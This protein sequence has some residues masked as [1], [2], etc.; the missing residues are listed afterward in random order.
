VP[1][2]AMEADA[3]GWPVAVRWKGMRKPLFAQGTGDLVV[4]EVHGFSPRWLLVDLW[5]NHAPD[6]AAEFCREHVR[7]TVATSCGKVE[8]RDNPHTRVFIQSLQHPR[9]LWA[10][11][12]LEVWKS[13]PRARLTLR[14]D[15]HSSLDPEIILAA[16]CL[17]CDDVLPQTSCGGQPFTPFID[18]LPGTCR[19]YFAIDHYVRYSGNEGHWYWV[20]RDCPTVAF[21][22]P[23][24]L[25]LHADRPA[26]MNRLHAIVFNNCWNTNW[27]ADSHGVMEFQFD[28]LWSDNRGLPVDGHEL[29]ECVTLDPPILLQPNAKAD[30]LLLRHVFQP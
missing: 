1:G 15:R 9:F 22:S 6:A 27:V 20:S 29:A 24:V 4:V 13:E 10:K 25:A 26:D 23:P 21:G 8:V 28:L 12:R 17:P 30:A 18:Q 19:D 11:R 7:Q 2:P 16:F 14:F 5:A 3:D